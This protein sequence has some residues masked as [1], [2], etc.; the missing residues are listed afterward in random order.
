MKTARKFGTLEDLRQVRE[1]YQARLDGYKHQA[2]VCAGTGCLSANS[3][4]VAAALKESVARHGIEGQVAVIPEGGCVGTCS[5]GPV[6]SVLPD[7]AYY[8]ELTPEKIDQIVASH[9]VEGRPV[10]EH[11]F[12]DAVQ[13]KRALNVQSVAFFRDQLR[14]ALRNC[15]VIDVES[16]D[17]YISRDGYRAIALALERGPVA[18]VEEIKRSG[19]RGRGGAGFPT[20]VKWEACL[21]AEGAQ[22]YIVCN[23]DE[24]DPGA[25]MDRT[26]LEGDPHSVIEGMMIGGY[27][28]GANQG[29][30]YLRAEYPVAEQRLAR[31]IEQA[32]EVGLLGAPLFGSDFSFDLEIRVGAGA[33]VCGEETALM[34][35]IEGKRGEPRQKPP[36]PFQSGLFGCPTIINNVETLA[37]VAPI[38]LQ[39]ADWYAGIG[40]ETSKGT[41]VF[42]L[43]GDV[44]NTG[45]VEVPMGTAMGDLLFSIGGGIQGGK[46]LKSI[47]AGGPSGGCITKGFLNTP[48]DYESIVELGAI[49]GSGGLVVM[50][51]DTCMVDTAR[52]FMDFIQDESCGKC[53]PCRIGTKR[54]LEILTRITRGEGREGDIELMQE[55]CFYIQ[56]TAM[57]GLGQSAPNPVLSTI[58]R[59]REEYEEH[60][61]ER[62]CRAGVCSDLVLS[63]CQN[64]CPVGI[65]IPGYLALLA[66]GQFGEAYRL[67]R[68]ENPLAAV[69]GT[70]C[71]H[72][73]ESKCRRA[74]TDEAVAICALQRFV[75]D[76]SGFDAGFDL[77]EGVSPKTGKSVGIVGAGPSGLTCAHYLALLGHDVVVYD[78][79]PIAGGILAYGIPEYRLP[80]EVLSRE[81]DLI[82]AEGVEIRLDTEIGRDIT[83]GQLRQA[84]QAIYVAAGAQIS[85]RLGIEGEHLPGVVYGLQ[86]LREV[87]LDRGAHPGHRVVVVGGGSTAFDAARAAVR[88]GA[89][90]VTVVYRREVADMPASE[91]E[92]RE[93]L[94][95]G[96][97]VLPLAGPQRVVGRDRAE[98]LECVR[99]ELRGFDQ[100]G[101]RQVHPIS[102]DSFLVEFD[103]LVLAVGQSPDRSL[104]GGEVTEGVFTG[105]D[106]A[107]GADVAI[108]AIADGKKAASYI[109][110]YLGGKG[111]LNKGAPVEYPAPDD[112]AEIEPHKRFPITVL[113][114][115][116][117][118]GNFKE[119]V[120]GYHK[121]DAIAESKRCL[122][123]DRR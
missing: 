96:V 70:I 53:V 1:S 118:V 77:S 66:A 57:C 23:A 98:A 75:A 43:A 48:V 22:K 15:G 42:A 61:Q 65:N 33:F 109:D 104:L 72:P 80:N 107:R 14:I 35:S 123:C 60:I 54:L 10:A 46:P 69:C 9:F 31:A 105:G 108:T 5:V 83:I 85:N 68:R 2:L 78:R 29:F 7:G 34:N 89:K 91:T 40:T 32:R 27:A 45:I 16:V 101:R 111:V 64:A 63:P 94:E 12:Y 102:Q 81:V 26:I 71:T 117:R 79:A 18:T 17:A 90:K 76:R 122:R 55:L 113:S 86:F 110:A 100:A 36:F 87:N 38:I 39:G 97:E 47:Q 13:G 92:I 25:F 20:G 88:L 106:F 95:E 24:G 19:L 56:Q 11:A 67:A 115:P 82:R 52:Y 4:A 28:I 3:G 74:Q 116:E 37:N 44:V 41:K 21:K 49:M 119:V 120:S 103:R 99:M 58:T 114:P 6:V 62:Y 121:L 30:V 112:A 84:H 59:F 8:T 73:C 93:A 51:E 50:D